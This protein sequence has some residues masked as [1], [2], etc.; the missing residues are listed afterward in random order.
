MATLEGPLLVLAGAG[1]GKT[2]VITARIANLLSRGVPAA[3]ILAMTFT[4]K[5]ATEMRERVSRSVKGHE[6]SRSRASKDT[7][8]ALSVGTF[9]WFCLRLLRRHAASVGFPGGFAIADAADQLATVKSVLRELRIGESS[10]QPGLVLSRISL[11]KNRLQTPES[12]DEQSTT[13]TE[14]VVQQVWIRYQ[15]ALRRQ[16]RVDFDDLLLLTLSLFRDRPNTLRSLRESYRYIMVDEYQDTNV[17]QYEILRGLAG[18]RKNL[19]VVGDDDQSI[20]G[21][22]GA[23]VRKILNFQRDFKGARVVRLETNYRSSSEILEGANRVIANN[24]S[25]HDK[26]LKSAR[27]SGAPVRMVRFADELVEAQEIT[28]EI[29]KTCMSKQA[30]LSDYA[31]LFRTQVQPRVFETELRAAG[32]PYR[33]VGGMSYFDRKEVRDT[34]A[35]LK[36][37]L[38]PDDESSLLRIIN[39]P[40]R[41]IG[42]TT[43][44]RAVDLATERGQTLHAV[45]SEPSDETRELLGERPLAGYGQ[46]RQLVDSMGLPTSGRDLPERIQSLVEAI[47][48][49]RELTRLYPDPMIRESRWA[50]GHRG[51]QSCREPL[52]Q[53]S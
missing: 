36:W 31:I 9:H 11:A 51:L 10:I 23:D 52:P 35:L 15:D 19:C 3:S 46:L 8:E 2:R 16:K 6:R 53:A 12:L 47:G 27:G 7:L 41:G 26:K 28:K 32:I 44:D 18:T 17:P 45:L 42:K 37:A 20:Y 49:R 30:R 40:P 33:L 25:R 48:Y 29:R 21:W 22:R 14:H 13:H 1:S 39:T 50:A 5:A 24:P 43:V 38:N 4:N 34:L